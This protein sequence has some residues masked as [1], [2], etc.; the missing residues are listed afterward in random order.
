MNTMI[1]HN[2]ALALIVTLV[3]VSTFAIGGNIQKR[4]L[5]RISPQ[6]NITG[7]EVFAESPSQGIGYPAT[8]SVSPG[9]SIDRSSYDLG[10]NASANHNFI[11]YGSTVAFARMIAHDL[12]AGTLDRDSWTACSTNGGV[13]WP[14]LTKVETLRRGWTNIFNN[15]GIAG[16]VSHTG[17]EVNTDAA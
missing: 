1:L 7:E 13:T 10:S 14:T 5:K 17:L 8:Y 2:R 3:L 9:D 11:N 16:T 15:N 12:S 4:T 6:Q